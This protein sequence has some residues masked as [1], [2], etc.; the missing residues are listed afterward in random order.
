[1]KSRRRLLLCTLALLAALAACASDNV[2]RGGPQLPSLAIPG[3]SDTPT[4]SG[5]VAPASPAQFVQ[6]LPA[7]HLSTSLP[8]E[9]APSL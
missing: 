5:D 9:V 3:T 1:M 8:A 7:L 6:A 2:P 4:P